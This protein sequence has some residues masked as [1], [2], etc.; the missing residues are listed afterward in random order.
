[1]S[2]HRE[3][4][5]VAMDPAIPRLAGITPPAGRKKPDLFHKTFSLRENVL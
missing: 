3:T 4:A 2:E 1:M 5:N